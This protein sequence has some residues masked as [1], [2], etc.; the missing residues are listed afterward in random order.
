MK[1][2]LAILAFMNHI[3]RTKL[4][5]FILL[6]FLGG[7]FVLFPQ[8]AYANTVG[9]NTPGTMA[10]TTITGGTSDWNY[11]GS[12]MNNAEIEDGVMAESVVG[13]NYTKCLAPDTII[14]TDDG[15]KEIKDIK[16]GD[17][18]YS[19]NFVT[20]KIELKKVINIINGPLSLDKNEFYH[21]YFTNGDIRATYDHPFY[22]NGQLVDA[23]DLK[24]GDELFDMYGRKETINKIVIEKDYTDYSYGITIADNHNFFANE[25]LV[26]NVGSVLDNSVQLIKGGT[27]GSNDASSSSAWGSTLATSTYGGSGNLWGNGWNVSDINASNFG[28]AISAKGTGFSAASLKSFYLEATNFGFSIPTGSTIN[29]ITVKIKKAAVASCDGTSHICAGID[30]INITVDYTP[31]AASAPTVTTSAAL[32][33]T[34]TAMTMN[35]AI[36]ANGGADA[37]QS[38]FAYSTDSALVSGVSTTTDGAQTGAVSFTHLLSNLPTKTTYYFRAY[39]TNS[40]DTGYGSIVSSATRGLGARL[41]LPPNFLSAQSSGLVGY[42]TFDGKNMINNVTDSSGQG[43]NGAMIGFTSTSSAQVPGKIGQGLKFNGSN[44]YI[45][46]PSYNGVKT[47]SFWMR[48]D[49]TTQQILQL[50][51]NLAS[52]SVSSGTL[53]ANNFTSPTIY[54]DG[55]VTP[56]VGTGWHFITITTGTGINASAIQIGKTGTGYYSGSLDDVRIYNRT[57]STAEIGQLYR[58]GSTRVSMPVTSGSLSSSLVG[59]WTFDG[60]NMINNVADTSGQGNNGAMIGFTSTSTAQ[61]AGKIGQGLKFNGSTSYVTGPSYNGVKTVSFWM[62]P[63]STTQQILQLDANLASTSVSG[64]T[65]SANNFTSPTIYVDGVVTSTVTTGWHFITITTGTGINASAIQIGK[66]GTGY[67]SGSLDDVRVYSRALSAAEVIQL[68][69]FGT[70][71]VKP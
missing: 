51:A 48:P 7:C 14:P 21:I 55:V 24:I 5:V 41:S 49:G 50:D 46:G 42:W 9:P 19:Y 70:A 58:A 62:R 29:G 23:E 43:N 37:T 53:S 35:G 44:S 8:N 17:L 56:T 63:D 65:L 32:W 12:S 11:N 18:V 47:I 1:K 13:T 54:V 27:I 20:D 26:H 52:T 22:V 28:V 31:A 36:T 57:L 67:Y 38:G 4:P 25:V 69:K 64:G 15:D 66:T 10:T 30:T 2:H 60:K 33:I 45:T 39:A 6:A 3:I 68:Y 16:I 40:S 61:V 59:Y 71:K 34:G